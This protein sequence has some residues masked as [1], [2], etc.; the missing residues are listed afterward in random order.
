MKRLN[1]L[2][3]PILYIGIINGLSAQAIPLVE[4]VHFPLINSLEDSLQHVEDLIAENAPFAGADGIY[5][6]GGFS[7]FNQTSYDTSLIRSL[8]IPELADT[9]FGISLEF[10]LDTLDQMFHPIVV[11]GLS[12]R[13]LSIGTSYN[14]FTGMDYYYVNLNNGSIISNIPVSPD[15]DV[16][17][18]LFIYHSRTRATTWFFLDGAAVD[19][20]SGTLEDGGFDY[21]LSNSDFGG[22]FAYRGHWRHLR[23][24]RSDVSSSR[25]LE[26][27]PAGQFTVSPN[28]VHSNRVVR[29]RSDF[30]GPVKLECIGINGQK[31]FEKFLPPGPQNIEIRDIPEG[32]SVWRIG[33]NQQGYLSRLLICPY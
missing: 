17:H 10:K 21:N 29:I 7:G 20:V 26:N 30:A 23:I 15:V 33:N 8:T 19:T 2:I 22:A 4:V 1:Y 25:I 18:Q 27:G 28:P 24:F 9:S 3:L 6:F 32:I 14:Q 11:L 12:Y 5:S 13:Y 16:W 31:Y